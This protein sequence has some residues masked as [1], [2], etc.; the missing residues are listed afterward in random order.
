MHDSM[1]TWRVD[2]RLHWGF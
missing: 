1:N 2:C